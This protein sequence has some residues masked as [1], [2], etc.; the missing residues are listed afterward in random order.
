MQKKLRFVLL[1]VVL[2]LVLG[3]AY[4]GYQKLGSTVQTP[5]IS[6]SVPASESF[7][8]CTVYTADGRNV[9]LSSLLDKPVVVNFWAT[10]CP[11]CVEEFPEL[12]K[13]F[14]DYGDKVNFAMVNYTDGVR[15]TVETASAYIAENGYTF[16]VY[17]DLDSSALDNYGVYSF[18]TTL[19]FAPDGSQAFR[20][21]GA[22][23]YEMV[24]GRLEA[25]T[26]QG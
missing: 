14:E 3:G 10:W 21:S 15:E 7:T 17:Y 9:A 6:V 12:Q 4:A 1:A 2:V 22:L 20:Y 8:D 5:D 26:A 25:L 23:T 24:A 18:P 13:A 11:F 19:I 16:P